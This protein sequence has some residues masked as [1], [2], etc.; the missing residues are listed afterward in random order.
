M[1]LSGVLFSNCFGLKKSG[2]R[3]GDFPLFLLNNQ[4]YPLESGFLNI[5]FI[6]KSTVELGFFLE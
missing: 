6:L 2:V 1:L 3:E 5:S 4:H